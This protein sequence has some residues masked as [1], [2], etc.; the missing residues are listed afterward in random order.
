MI[1]SDVY[2]NF[3]IFF[4]IQLTKENL[5]EGVLK[6]KREFLTSVTSFFFKEQL[7]LVYWRQIDFNG[8]VNEI[9]D[10]FLGTLTDI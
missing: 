5:W 7:P 1:K 10:R 9:Y 6:I 3:P 4:S 2:D 8:T